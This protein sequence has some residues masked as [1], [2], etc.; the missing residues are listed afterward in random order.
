MAT[1]DGRILAEINHLVGW[2]EFLEKA[3][4]VQGR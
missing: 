4:A 2:Q 1:P 3:K